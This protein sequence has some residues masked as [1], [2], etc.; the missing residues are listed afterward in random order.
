MTNK[1][2][3]D[4]WNNRYLQQQTGWDIGNAST[5]LKEYIEQ[6]ADKNLRILIPGCGNAHEAEILLQQN[7]TNITLID[8]AEEAVKAMKDKYSEAIAEGRLRVL[9]QDFFTL[10]E[11]FDLI[12]EQTFFC[13][14]S[15]T[16]RK[17]YV[18]KM[19]EVLTEKGKIVGVLF[20]CVFEKDGPPFGGSTEEY[21]LLFQEKFNL[22]KMELC[23]NS[24]SP[25][26]GN[27]VFII[28]ERK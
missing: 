20:N 27:E 8:I 25:R 15:P 28:F 6:I 7:F 10:S 22:K 4:Y 24:I 18:A 17:E 13:A 19:H 21:Q 26:K 2:N 9:Q 23:Y 5:P 14:L 12:L 16:L 3:Q 1:F 11:K